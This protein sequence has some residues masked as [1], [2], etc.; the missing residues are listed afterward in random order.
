MSQQAMKRHRGILNAYYQMKQDN[1]K[2]LHT[3]WFELHDILEKGK[4]LE[5]VKRSV[6]A[7]GW[8]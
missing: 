1:L 7:M 5:T 4:T 6:I 8:V 3:V 2:R